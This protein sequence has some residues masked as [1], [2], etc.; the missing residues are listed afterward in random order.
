MTTGAKKGWYMKIPKILT[1]ILVLSLVGGLVA[2]C[3]KKAA[4]TTTKTLTATV[5]KGSLTESITGTGNLA[6]SNVEKL[7]FEMAG[8]VEAVMVSA[9]DTVKKG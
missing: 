6:Y 2:G 3:T 9:G 5:R 1:L 8:Y 7:A 4:T